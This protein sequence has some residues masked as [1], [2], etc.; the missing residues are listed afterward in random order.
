MTYTIDKKVPPPFLNKR[1][2]PEKYPLTR[3]EVGDSFRF[4]WKPGLRSSI[5]GCAYQKWG[6]ER[7]FVT[8]AVE[9]DGKMWFR[10]WRIK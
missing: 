4:A 10:I 5:R 3:M 2:W 7:R 6:N 1:G 8:K 9:E